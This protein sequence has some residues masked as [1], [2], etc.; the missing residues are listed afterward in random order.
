M[1]RREDLN[2]EINN[3]WNIYINANECFLYS[4]YLNNAETQLEFDYI[5]SSRDFIYIGQIMWQTS[6]IELSKLFSDSKSDRFRI[7]N[8][9]SKLKRNGYLGNMGITD[10]VLNQWE[11]KIDENK[12][13]IN[14]ILTLRNKVYAHT[15]SKIKTYKNTNLSFDKIELLLNLVKEIII[16]IYSAA[17]NT[18]ADIEPVIF[19]KK[20][21]SI[22]IQTLAEEKEKEL[23]KIYE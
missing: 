22:I 2:N 21:F 4:N 8:L 23:K 19:N 9:I 3:I 5:N 18:F 16:K 10:E 14:S 6:I 12:E 17:F 1:G 11:T 7:L 13:L 15:D 20:R